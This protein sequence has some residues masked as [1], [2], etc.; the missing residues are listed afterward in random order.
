M[1]RGGAWVRG[2]V[3]TLDVTHYRHTCPHCGTQ[4]GYTADTTGLG[5]QVGAILVCDHCLDIGI[6]DRALGAAPVMRK[7]TEAEQTLIAAN[8]AV[9]ARIESLRG[10]FKTRGN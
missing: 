8:P 7:L 9:L 2:D 1:V 3:M 6:L 4:H 5:L 10:H